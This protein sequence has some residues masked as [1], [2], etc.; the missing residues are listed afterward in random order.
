MGHRMAFEVLKAHGIW[1]VKPR[2]NKP[3]G[4]HCFE[5]SIGIGRRI[6]IKCINTLQLLFMTSSL[7]GDLKGLA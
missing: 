2:F 4:D 3:V 7:V 1:S 5:L 6:F